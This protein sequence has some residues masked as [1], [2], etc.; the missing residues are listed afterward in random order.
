[1]IDSLTTDYSLHYYSLLTAHDYSLL[2]TDYSLTR[3]IVT[4]TDT[5]LLV[6]VTA[7]I[8]ECHC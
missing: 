6:I 3:V 8:S 5:H 2:T 7:S 4:T 1:M